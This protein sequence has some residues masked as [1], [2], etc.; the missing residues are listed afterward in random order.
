MLARINRNYVPAYWDDFFNDRFFTQLNSKACNESNAAVN[1]SEDDRGYTIEVA[2]PGIDR[3]EFNLELEKDVLTIST[4]QKESK[5]DNKQN[6]IRREF[7]YQSFK[8]SFQLPE[9]VDQEGI[10][11][12]H[13]AGILSLSLPKKKEEV[14]KAPRQIEVLG[15]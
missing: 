2:A 15:V 10:K 4:G 8:R 3:K 12:T 11:A 9:T 1:V 13:N 6:F 14:E 7:N 5:E